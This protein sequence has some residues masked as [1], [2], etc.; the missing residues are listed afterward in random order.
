MLNEDLLYAK[1]QKLKAKEAKI[2][3]EKRK[4][5]FH[6]DLKD[7]THKYTTSKQYSYRDYDDYTRYETVYICC[8]CHATRDEFKT[9]WNVP[10]LK[11]F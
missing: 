10:K 7:C 3:E 11:I 6:K 1:L 2:W 5:H 9:E 8:L 4:I